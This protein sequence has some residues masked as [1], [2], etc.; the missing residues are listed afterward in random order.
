MSTSEQPA[1]RAG[2]FSAVDAVAGLLAASSVVLSGFSMSLGFILG[3]DASPARL[4][5]IAAILSIVAAVMSDRFR[6]MALKAMYL[7]VV[8]WS[9]GMTIAVLVDAPL[10]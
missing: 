3:L 5:P 7:S 8:A 6:P 9:V 1:G 10:F 2:G 4:A